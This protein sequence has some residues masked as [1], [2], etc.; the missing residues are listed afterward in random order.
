ML[1][2]TVQQHLESGLPPAEIAKNIGDSHAGLYWD[3]SEDDELTG[4]WI[5]FAEH[6]G[7]KS[8]TK[9]R[10]SVARSSR[11]C[12]SVYGDFRP[13]RPLSDYSIRSRC[14]GARRARVGR[15]LRAPAIGTEA[16]P[17]GGL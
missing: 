15:R 12:S 16:A 14:Q 3:R 6:D 8:P 11:S 13:Q 4:E 5:I 9:S 2:L 17:G 1:K 7:K 10:A